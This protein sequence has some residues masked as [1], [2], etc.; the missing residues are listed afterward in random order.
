MK[1]LLT[2]FFAILVSF[3]SFA[4][5]PPIKFGEI[6]IED[7]QMTKYPKD[8]SASAVILVDFGTSSLVYNQSS[9]FSLV[10][11]RM[12]RIKILS[13]EG[14]DWATFTVPL[15][16]EGS[17][18]EKFSSLKAATYNLENKEVVQSKLRNDAVFKE[19]VNANIDY[20]KF[21][22]PNVKQG[23][24]IEV[25]YKITSDFL[26]NFQDWEFQSTIPTRWSEY[27]AVI[28]E[29]YYYERYTQGYIPMTINETKQMPASITLSSTERSTS[30]WT[31][32][33]QTSYDKIDYTENKYRWAV[34][35][36]PAFKPEPFITTSKDYI[37]KINF[38]LAYKKFPGQAM[39]PIM[40]TWDDI[41]KQY[42]DSPNF[43]KEVTGNGFLRKVSEEIT[44]GLSTPEQK[45]SAI[46]NY[47]KRNIA[48]NGNSFKFT[49]TPLKK[50]LEDKKGSSA[51]INLLM[52]SLLD[53]A[54]FSVS[55]V[56]ISTRDHGFIR[57]TVAVSSQF[58][59]VLCLV[60]V[61]DKSILLDGT[62]QY[63]GTGVLPE[64]CMNG[65]GFVVSETGYKWFPLRA[66]TKSRQLY[67]ADLVLNDEGQLKGKLQLDRSGYFAYGG[68]QKYL[69][70][71]ESEYVKD[72]IG[73]RAW[74]IGK[75]EFFNAKDVAQPFKETHE[76]T[77]VDH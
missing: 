42:S 26:F 59:Y 34:E 56:L 23:S 2:G 52:A 37:S 7:L 39:Q 13:K 5:K 53:K 71:G 25:T 70:K 58:N 35:N 4:Q 67:S 75:S 61:E 43:G 1:I 27:R 68:R 8:T 48:W 29:F 30:G 60:T 11:D 6:P 47:V 16:H 74:T 55:P 65:N 22:M 64:R 12:M 46:N 63:L 31:T 20:M 69:V 3:Y 77:I 51:E 32:A 73:N 21:T 33:S 66:M 36:V 49:D 44:A 17:G 40:G 28:P 24:V 50:V 19:K 41:N 14:L 76:I 18:D 72:L 15:Y 10:F 62:D 38:E 45:I 57:E 9:G 54:G